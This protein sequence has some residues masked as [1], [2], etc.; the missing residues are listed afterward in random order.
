MATQLANIELEIAH[1][2][3]CKRYIPGYETLCTETIEH[4]LNMGLFQVSTAFEHAIAYCN[5]TTVVSQNTH[6]FSNG[7]DG[8]YASVRKHSRNSYSAQISG[9]KNKIGTLRI[10]V[11]ERIQNEFYYF[12]IP[13]SAHSTVKHLEIPFYSDG[14][15]KHTSRWWDWQVLTFEL[16]AKTMFSDIEIKSRDPITIDSFFG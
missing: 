4:L 6:D 16:M 13:Y 12:V 10:Q 8:K 5:G 9:T 2:H 7:D 14:Y 11:Y 15:P 1:F 3:N